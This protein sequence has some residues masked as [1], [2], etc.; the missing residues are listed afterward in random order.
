MELNDGRYDRDENVEFEALNRRIRLLESVINNFPGGLLLFDSDNRLVLY[1]DEQLHLLEYPEEFFEIPNPTLEQIFRINANRGEYGEGDAEKHVQ[2]RLALVEQ[3][4]A[5]TFERKRPNGTV[6]EIRG[7]PLKEGGFVTTYLD[8]TERHQHQN[9]INRMA[10]FDQLTGLPNR[11][12]MLDRLK[13]ALAGTKRGQTIALHY[14]DVDRFKI[15]NDKFGHDVGDLVLKKVALTLLKSA[16]ETDTVARIGGDEF[17][18]IQSE[19]DSVSDAN[20]MAQ[21]VIKNIESIIFAED[22]DIDVGASIGVAFAPWDAENIDELLRKADMAMYRSKK[23]TS[24]S[25]SYYSQ[26]EELRKIWR[27]Q[28][29][30]SRHEMNARVFGDSAS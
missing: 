30:I 27:D 21:R 7:V 6:L 3:R 11:S 26:V 9:L 28:G 14:I 10:H 24:G 2:T 25:V 19:V 8:V 1:N 29:S 13:I 23:K 5:H 20:A 16:R 4:C 12:L 18:I 15:V 17:I 22:L